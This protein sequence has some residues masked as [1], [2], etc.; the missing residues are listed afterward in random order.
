MCSVLFKVTHTPGISP[1]IYCCTIVASF[2]FSKKALTFGTVY[3]FCCMT[4]REVLERK[5]TKKPLR[6]YRIKNI[7]SAILLEFTDYKFPP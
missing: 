1:Q 2:S 6:Y 7:F 3:K 4:F 5:S